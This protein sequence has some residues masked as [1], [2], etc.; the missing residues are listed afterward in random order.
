MCAAFLNV[1]VAGQVFRQANKQAELKLPG[2][3]VLWNEIPN[4]SFRGVSTV[5]KGGAH[6]G[7]NT[8]PNFSTSKMG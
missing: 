7:P 3:E 6:C 5:L 1:K 8:T 2:P 4:P